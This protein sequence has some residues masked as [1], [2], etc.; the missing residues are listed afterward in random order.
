MRKSDGCCLISSVVVDDAR[1]FYSG[2][3]SRESVQEEGKTYHIGSSSTTRE[4]FTHRSAKNVNFIEA[5]CE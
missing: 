2:N 4:L 3:L 5:I 1:R